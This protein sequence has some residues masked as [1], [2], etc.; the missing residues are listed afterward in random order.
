MDIVDKCFTR[1]REHE[2]VVS[3]T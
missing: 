2:M 1:V 3:G